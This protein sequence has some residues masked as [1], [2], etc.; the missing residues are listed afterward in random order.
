MMSTLQH[1][2]QPG[3]IVPAPAA[4]CTPTAPVQ[5]NFVYVFQ[6]SG[7]SASGR[8]V[9]LPE[10]PALFSATAKTPGSLPQRSG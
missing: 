10:F 1:Y 2:S 5:L 3:S 9:P 7:E 4:I 6:F 8:F